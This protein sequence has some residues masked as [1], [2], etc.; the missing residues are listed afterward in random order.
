[1]IKSVTNLSAPYIESLE[2]M[3]KIKRETTRLVLR[4]YQ[5]NRQTG[6]IEIL[7]E[8]TLAGSM[9]RFLQPHNFTFLD[10]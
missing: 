3:T 9:G 8:W 7:V 1:M 5:E 6:P 2:E 10:T 4:H